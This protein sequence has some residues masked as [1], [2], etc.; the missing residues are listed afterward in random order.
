MW[1]ARRVRL[2]GTAVIAVI[3]ALGGTD[4]FAQG[5]KLRCD[6]YKQFGCMAQRCNDL[7]TQA[8]SKID[9]DA[10]K[11]SICDKAGCEALDFVQWP[12]GIYVA[13]AFPGRELMAKINLT[14][15]SIIE[16]S[17]FLS[18]SITSFGN[19]AAERNVR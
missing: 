1:S 6:F 14:D 9:F 15:N 19:C 7:G 11:Y 3:L 17:T 16:T 2:V 13:L 4:A 18:N 5:S 8:W 10:K 12:D